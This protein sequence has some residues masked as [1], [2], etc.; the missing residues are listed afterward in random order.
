M[1]SPHDM[2][3]CWSPCVQDGKAKCITACATVKC[4][5][6]KPKCI[7][8]QA[9]LLPARAA[10][11]LAIACSCCCTQPVMLASPSDPHSAPLHLLQAG[12][13]VCVKASRRLV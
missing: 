1:C 8:N 12:Q 9:S 4:G 5:A 6:D 13:A 10:A 3:G 2:H 7:V 11:R